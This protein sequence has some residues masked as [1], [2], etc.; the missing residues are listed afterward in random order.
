MAQPSKV[1][2]AFLTI[3]ALPF[4]GGGLF[5]LYGLLS[6]SP[7]FH[8]SNLALGI[9]VAAF[10]VLVGAGLIF[11]AFKGY[12]L[13]KKQAALQ[14]ANPLLPWLWRADWSLKRAE[15]VNKK[16]YI[17]A[18]IGAAF[19]TLITAP[20]MLG[21]IPDLLRKSDP[22][23][24][25]LLGFNLFSA[26]LIVNAIRVTI[27]H[28]RFGN[29]YCE[30]DPLPISPGRR[31][32]GRIQLRFETQAAHGID[33]HLSCVRRIVTGSGK[34]QTTSKVTLWQADKNVPSGALEPGPLGRA[35]PV[36]FDI[37][38]D[39]LITDHT[40]LSDQILWQ[41]H[42]KADV[43]GVDY[44]DDFELPVFRTADSPQPATDSSAE[45]SFDGSTGNFGFATAKS[46]DADSGDVAQPARTKVVVSMH[47]GGTEFYFPPLR[48]PA[49]ALMLFVVALVFSGAVYLL[50][51][52]HVSVLFT[53]LFALSDLL[54]IFG[55]FHVTFGSARIGVG[56][57]EILSRRGILGMGTTRRFPVSDVASIVPVGSV[58]QGGNSDDN[59]IYSI[60]LH[61]KSGQKLTLADEIS[62]RQEA[63][64]VVSQLETL[65]GLKLDTH[66]EVSLPL[67]VQTQPVQLRAG[68]PNVRV[69][70]TG[71]SWVAFAVFGAMVLAMFAWQA[72]W[73][74]GAR[75]VRANTSR[76]ASRTG[77]VSR[78]RPVPPRVFSGPLTDAEVT[79]VLA[80]PAQ[81]QA[82]ELFER[83]IGHDG[84]ALEVFGQ[85]FDS[86]IGHINQSDRLSQLLQRAQF[87]KDLRVRLAHVDM[88][89]A[90]QG[91]HENQQAVDSLLNRASTDS[92]YRGWA[93]FY[94]GMLAA[95]G[96]DYDRIHPALL[97]Y[98]RTDK[99]PNVRQWAVEGLR[100][101]AKDDVLD[102][103]YTSFT[104][105]PSMKV[106]DRAGCNIAD[107]GI[108]TR[109]QRM[110][111]VP[112]LI[113]LA[114]D[115][116][117]SAQMRSWSFMALQE[118][119]DA[120]VPADAP[121][122]NRWYA[123]HGAEKMAEFG[124]LEWW[125]VRGNE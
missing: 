92:Q 81:A 40:N 37:P 83:L 6:S 103:L 85:Q 61:T 93:V 23:V 32:T 63:R 95:R 10:F 46:V 72:R 53:A 25:L 119:T 52:N 68:R 78:P 115:A 123:D 16:S 7:N 56:N 13:L 66:V 109:K 4:L 28:E 14:E 70:T 18:W 21:L 88:S 100:F 87:S 110:R 120:A 104:E 74:V 33:L 29:S 69:Q 22:R 49:R 107:C 118:I 50:I 111:M 106:R 55:F 19:C 45:T 1:G 113:D 8:A 101:L 102:E 114:A 84:R 117:T 26:I 15:S 60:Q 44:S 77:G 73:N 97:N 57:G 124:R 24:F 17:T 27:R 9:I 121:A 90:L 51:H 62:S 108:F 47:D 71:S 41:L 91:F 86:W 116:K 58:Q 34:N 82:E 54:V 76:T 59:S 75:S 125:Q 11:G 39:A 105:D 99:D 35:I 94:L 5:F 2:P 89:L 112:K 79:R 80:L 36:E 67:G 43:P 64:W 20:F 98:A 38:A 3:F 31:M 65:S 96:V 42:A 30:F 12:G 48:T 122:W